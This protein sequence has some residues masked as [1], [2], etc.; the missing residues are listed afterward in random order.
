[1]RKCKKVRKKMIKMM[2]IPKIR[3]AL[4]HLLSNKLLVIQFIVHAFKTKTF[5]SKIT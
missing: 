1:M 3:Q 5:F 2:T 4:K